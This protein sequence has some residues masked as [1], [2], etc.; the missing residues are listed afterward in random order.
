M[1]RFAAGI[2]ILLLTAIWGI[3]T[4]SQNSDLYQV[5]QAGYEDAL[6]RREEGKNLQQRIRDI[7]KNSMVAG[8]DQKFTVERLLDIGAPRMEWKFVGQP[9]VYGANKALYRHTFRIAGPATYQDSQ[10]LMRKLATLPGF[11]PYRYCFGCALT[12]KGVPDNVKMV[13]VEGYLYVYDPN[14]FY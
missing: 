11:V 6:T 8:D 2:A 13:Q 7:R 4:Y 3:Y 9:R 5:K 14:T 10:E 1:M 12:P